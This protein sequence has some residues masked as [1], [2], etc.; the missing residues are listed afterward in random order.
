MYPRHHFALLLFFISAVLIN[1][2]CYLTG[3]LIC[4]SLLV[5]YP[6]Q[7]LISYLPSAH[8]VHDFIQFNNYN[9]WSF[10]VGY[11]NSLYILD[12]NPLQLGSN[13]DK[14]PTHWFV[15]LSGC[16]IKK[17]FKKTKGLQAFSYAIFQKF[18]CNWILQFFCC[19]FCFLL[20]N[21]FWVNFCTCYEIYIEIHFHY[22]HMCNFS[23]H[24]LKILFLFK[25]LLPYLE[26]EFGVWAME[27]ASDSYLSYVRQCQL[28]LYL[29]EK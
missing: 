24:L 11:A 22:Q 27:K 13:F 29:C 2:Q 9:A 10:V 18:T 19:W 4:I 20:D 17:L 26:I 3:V 14:N 5:S 8:T 21:P 23:Q 16:H 15:F 25:I 7:L 1:I 28:P 6:E 12:M